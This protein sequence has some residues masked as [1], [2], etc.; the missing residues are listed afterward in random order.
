MANHT[1]SSAIAR[2]LLATCVVSVAALGVG[3]YGLL[4]API[5]TPATAPDELAAI[6]KDLADLRHSVDITRNQLQVPGDANAIADL[7]R[8]LAQLETSARLPRATSPTPSPGAP[9]A[10]DDDRDPTALTGDELRQRVAIDRSPDGVVTS[11][12]AD[13]A[14][15]NA[16]LQQR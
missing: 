4:R 14:L 12:V 5:P 9:A 15:V 13:P 8:R 11:S 7:E 1:D 16:A 3:I 6:R 10:A 2:I